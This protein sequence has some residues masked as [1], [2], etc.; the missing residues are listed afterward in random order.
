MVSK[1][2]VNISIVIIGFFM[3]FL[4]IALPSVIADV[5]RTFSLQGRLTDSSGLALNGNHDFN[6]SLWNESSG[7]S[8]V[9]IWEK[10]LY[11]REGIFSVDL[12][13]SSLNFSQ[14]YYVEIEVE[15]QTLEPRINLSSSP[16]AFTIAENLSRNLIPLEHDVYI[17]G[18]DSERWNKLWIGTGGI[19]SSGNLTVDTDTLFVDAD[20]DRVGIGTDNPSEAFVG[21]DDLVIKNTADRAGITIVSPTT[22]WGNIIFANASDPSST[23]NYIGYDHS[24]SLFHI[25]SGGYDALIINSST[26]DVDISNDLDVGGDVN[27]SGTIYAQALDTGGVDITAE[28]IEAIGNLTVGENVDITGNLT[29]DTGT[30]FV[31]ADN[32]MVGIG[33]NR[34]DAMLDVDVTGIGAL[35][36]GVG[37]NASGDRAVALGGAVIASGGRSVAMGYICNA[38]N[39][40]AVAMGYQTLASGVASTAMGY[41]TTASE[42]ASIA[43]GYNTLANGEYSTAIGYAAN[44]SASWSMAM[45]YQT[46]ASEIASTAMG[47]NTAASEKYSTAMGYNTAAS[48]K[49]ST[50]MGY[51]TAASGKY[52]TA[53]GRQTYA[54]GDYSTAIGY[55]IDANGEGTV[56]IALSDQGAASVTQDHTM[57]IMGGKVGIGTKTPGVALDV[58][59]NT[60]VA[61]NLTVGEN[62]DITGSRL[63]APNAIILGNYLAGNLS[64]VNNLV[65]IDNLT[66]YDSLQ[67]GSYSVDE[68][69]IEKHII[70]TGVVTKYVGIE[71]PNPW[72]DDNEG[73]TLKTIDNNTLQYS[74]GTFWGDGSSIRGF[75]IDAN[76][77]TDVLRSYFSNDPLVVDSANK[78]RIETNGSKTNL[79]VVASGNTNCKFSI[80][81]T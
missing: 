55:G 11:V 9:Y 19:V 33:T 58:R 73:C 3:L 75:K 13:A 44:A 6:F 21:A 40:S 14:P 41:N 10:T 38:T 64:Q 53:M 66:V 81:S 1:Q 57:A 27:V 12:D 31:D 67:I 51:H 79:A 30:L 77:Y 60:N 24:T 56:A 39:D 25:F 70:N 28:N 29:V 54:S 49:Y 18:N 78:C 23:N 4:I 45:G 52:S 69:C 26:G 72:C 59:G 42:I 2:A 74:Y 50:A 32:D 80:C 76:G 65:V 68:G 17:L 62:V 47:Y 5:P 7:G 8:Q 15:G 46:L 61:G 20:N 37:S 48:G 22:N 43:M 16:Y 34:P 35:E 63:Y 36:V 71:L